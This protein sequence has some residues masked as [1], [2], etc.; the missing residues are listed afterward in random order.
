MT[1]DVF[2]YLGD[3]S[4]ALQLEK[5]DKKRPGKLAFSTEHLET[6]S[7]KLERSG[8]YAHSKHF[9]ISL[10]SQFGL[11]LPHFSTIKLRKRKMPSSLAGY[12]YVISNVEQVE[13][14]PF[15]LQ[16]QFQRKNLKLRPS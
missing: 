13:G 8:R 7:F 4:E 11:A 1:P 10:C 12:I 16:R 2:I 15:G 9:I 14:P 5:A 6:G 3:L